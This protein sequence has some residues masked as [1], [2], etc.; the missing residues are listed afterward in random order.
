MRTTQRI[1][2]RQVLKLLGAAGT[3]LAIAACAPVA[4]AP[5]A[6]A[7][8][9]QAAAKGAPSGK[10]VMWA[11]PLTKNDP[12]AIWNPLIENVED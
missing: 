6:G 5:S 12:E 11:F 4:P 10:V 8:G 7:A 1:S 2:R 9:N 3:T